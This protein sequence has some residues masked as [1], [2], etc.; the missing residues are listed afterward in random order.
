MCLIYIIFSLL[1][2]F[3]V[4]AMLI[5]PQPLFEMGAIALY[6]ADRYATAP[7]G[8]LGAATASEISVAVA[9]GLAAA[10]ATATAGG[11][12]FATAAGGGDGA[13][14]GTAAA[15]GGAGGGATAA[16]G[17]D[18]AAT[19]G[20][21]S[22]SSDAMA[23]AQSF[24]WVLFSQTTLYQAMFTHY[25]KDKLPGLYKGMGPSW[26]SGPLPFMCTTCHFNYKLV[27]IYYALKKHTLRLGFRV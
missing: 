26:I 18:G 3:S 2:H 8:G 23:Y 22:S 1:F 7:G 13:A 11:G 14:T 17:G 24:Q 9:G 15:D 20:S 27:S 6:L 4:P 25:M 19:A 21:S 5:G 16:G 12:G 10:T